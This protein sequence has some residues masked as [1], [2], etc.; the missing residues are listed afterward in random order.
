[1]FCFSLKPALYIA[2]HWLLLRF[3]TLTQ[4]ICVHTNTCQRCYIPYMIQQCD[5]K[6]YIHGDIHQFT[7]AQP[8]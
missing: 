3:Y 7:A 8:I 5:Y 4:R 1:M 2:M 6:I